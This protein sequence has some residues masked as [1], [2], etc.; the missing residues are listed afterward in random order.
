MLGNWHSPTKWFFFNIVKLTNERKYV[1]LDGHHKRARMSLLKSFIIY[2]PFQTHYSILYNT[3]VSLINLNAYMNSVGS[4]HFFL[5]ISF[6]RT[7][8]KWSKFSE[9]YI[10]LC[11]STDLCKRNTTYKFNHIDHQNCRSKIKCICKVTFSSTSNL[12]SEKCSCLT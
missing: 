6:F 1:H 11:N 7:D 12:T 3:R 5:D 10:A 2:P 9:D 4:D 8:V